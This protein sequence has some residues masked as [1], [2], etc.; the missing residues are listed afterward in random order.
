[1]S[2]RMMAAVLALVACLGGAC[3][4]D[5]EE[6]GSAA[7]SAGAAQ[8]SISTAKLDRAFACKET[9]SGDGKG[10]PVLLVHGT[11]VTREQNWG[12]NYW[13]ALTDR[14]YDVCWVQLPDLAFGDIQTA[15]EYVARAVEVMHERT[16]ESID[17]IGHSQGGLEAR[18]AIKWF[19]AG[20]FVDDSIALATPHHGFAF[21]PDTDDGRAFEAGW[22]MRTGSNFLA[23]LNRGDE[24]AGP[25]DYTNI[26]SKTDELIQPVDT[27][28]LEGGTNVLLQDLCPG[29]RV[30]HG[31]IAGD[32][33]TYRLVLDALA[34][35]GTAKPNRAGIRCARGTFPGVGKPQFGPPPKGIDPH[36]TKQEPPLRPYARG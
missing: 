29:R 6:P 26:Y 2:N 25:I 16:G 5:D 20:A 11:T 15:S 18:W 10:D 33:V 12:W 4:G 32:D 36:L 21:E 14:G 34:N 3:G 31:G 22:Q 30:D 9:L 35:P 19:P 13:D 8:Y 28:A 23:A 7:L 27:Q 1:M 24:T 17:L